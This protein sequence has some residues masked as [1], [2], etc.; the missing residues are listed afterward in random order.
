MLSMLLEFFLFIF[1]LSTKSFLIEQ[2]IKEIPTSIF[3]FEEKN[4][5]NIEIK[6][7]GLFNFPNIK[8][9]LLEHKNFYYIFVEYME[10]NKD[11]KFN[12]KSASHII[13]F[14]KD[15]LLL[16][17]TNTNELSNSFVYY[18][19]FEGFE[20]EYMNK[21][22]NERNVDTYG[23]VIAMF[24]IPIWFGLCSFLFYLEFCIKN[25]NYN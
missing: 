7:D 20:K 8:K 17:I 22:I 5:S 10:R 14:F 23:F 25:Y 11:Y 4:N 15:E 21:E 2:R 16:K 3:T 19:N 13:F 24:G 18:V 1:F 12:I 6:I 9:S